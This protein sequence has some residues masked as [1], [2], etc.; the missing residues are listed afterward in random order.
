M[1]PEVSMPFAQ[2]HANGPYP[3]PDPVPVI[4]VSNLSFIQFQILFLGRLSSYISGGNSVILM[5]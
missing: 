3:Q 5:V 4:S 1:G 2:Q